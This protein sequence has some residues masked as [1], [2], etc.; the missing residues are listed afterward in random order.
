MLYVPIWLLRVGETV[1]VK[2]PS[3]LSK[4]ETQAEMSAP[5]ESVTAKL[6]IE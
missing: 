1:M 4:V 2:V 3:P 6:D 5:F